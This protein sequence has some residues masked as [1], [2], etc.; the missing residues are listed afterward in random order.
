M[1]GQCN[2]NREQKAVRET[3]I[4]GVAK[5]PDAEV[6]KVWTHGKRRQQ[7]SNPALLPVAPTVAAQVDGK[8]C[9][10]VSDDG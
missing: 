3:W 7:S 10:C 5:Q 4:C 2:G 6:I 8:A 9:A 1:N